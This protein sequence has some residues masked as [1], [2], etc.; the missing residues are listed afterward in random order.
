[1]AGGT[2]QRVIAV[3]EHFATDRYWSETANLAVPPGEVFA[4]TLGKVGAGRLM[5]A[6]D[7]PHED[8]QVASI[9]PANQRE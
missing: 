3:E 2:T 4:F 5:F 8:S 6:V 1:M 9:P 7:Y